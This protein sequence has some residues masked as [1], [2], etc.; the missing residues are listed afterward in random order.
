VHVELLG[1][2]SEG[3]LTLNGGQIN[4]RLE[5]RRV[6]ASLLRVTFCSV[7]VEDLKQEDFT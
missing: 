1:E 7:S 5:G 2:I 6:I 4:L 3:L